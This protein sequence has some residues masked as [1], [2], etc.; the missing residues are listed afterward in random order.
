MANQY[1]N[2][3]VFGAVSIIDITPTTAVESDVAEGKVF[4]KADGSR[5]VGTKTDQGVDVVETPDSHGGTIIEI[6]GVQSVGKVK[7]Y[8]IRPDAELVQTWTADEYLVADLG[9]TIPAY[10]TSAKTIL[11]GAA[12]SPVIAMDRTNYSYY[13]TMRGLAI[14]QYNTETKVKGRCDYGETAYLYEVMYVPANEFETIDGSKA[15]TAVNQAVT[16]N[17]SSGREIYWTSASAI[18]VA[19]NATYGAY[20][21]GQAPTL[22][23]ANL[24]VKAPI[25]GIRGNTTYM[26]STAWGQITDIREQYVIQVWRAPR[27]DVDG[28]GLLTSIRSIAENV[29]NG[30]NLT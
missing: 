6:T 9:L 11:T 18:A 2:K 23:G 3:V 27:G 13:V 21:T 26:T 20:V 12:L 25:Y 4:F 30:G 10:A 29:R 17:G 7:P 28:W 24:T 16:A 15:I 19:N 22:S 8:V 14:P 1:V 5:A